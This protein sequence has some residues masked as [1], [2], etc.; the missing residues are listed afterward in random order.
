MSSLRSLSSLAPATLVA[1]GIGWAV[2]LGLLAGS[3]RPLSETPGPGAWVQVALASWLVPFAFAAAC[4]LW[5]ALGLKLEAGLAGAGP[6][7]SRRHAVRVGLISWLLLGVPG[8][9]IVWAL[10]ARTTAWT[11]GVSEWQFGLS[12]LVMAPLARWLLGAMA[13]GLERV[14]RSRDGLLALGLLLVAVLAFGGWALFTASLRE[15]YGASQLLGYGLV[16]IGLVLSYFAW[17][18]RRGVRA[19][20]TQFASLLGLSACG[21]AALVLSPSRA[22]LEL[23]HLE[24]PTRWFARAL[25]AA[26]PDADGD[27][28]PRDLGFLRGGDCDDADPARSPFAFDVPGNAVDE[29]CFAG[30]A[31]SAL[32]S[33]PSVAPVAQRSPPPRPP[34]S[35]VIVIALDSLRFDRRHPSGVDPSVM[36]ELARLAADSFAFRDFRTCAPRTRESVPDLLGARAGADEPNAVQVLA[37]H[38]VHTAFIASDWLARHAVVPGFV[39]RTEPKARYGAFADGDVL[40]ALE[41]F[42]AGAPREPFFLFSH[43]LGAHE[44]YETGVGCP[45]DAGSSYARYECALQELD[46]KLGRLLAAIRESDIAERSVIAITADHGEEFREHGGRYHA[47]TLYDEVLHVP[48]V[49]HAPGRAP[50]LV[51][52]PVSCFDFL[53]TLL[54]AAHLPSS[55]ATRGED[56]LQPGEHPLAAQFARTRPA[57]ETAMFEPKQSVVV[58]AG[59]K[60]LWDRSTGVGVY[61][62]LARDPAERRPLA[63]PGPVEVPLRALMDAWLSEQ[64]GL[65]QANARLSLATQE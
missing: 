64:A 37:D 38:G 41:R 11:P 1:T 2:L 46:R 45:G 16:V 7:R 52:T 21:V 58:H 32:P 48:L 47:T 26:L 60:L 49:I 61:F 62:D 23:Y 8:Y 9:A 50:M 51:A 20:R 19:P 12:M 24:R 65:P 10:A 53:P 63:H 36:P 54:G 35:N 28:A 55:I 30:D 6:E 42:F 59:H 57:H 22:A 33:S 27:G 39:E 56:R 17:F 4:A 15:R 43:F 18:E 34:A 31:S 40:A 44:P 29:N 3:E 25:G 13:R 14:G 5:L